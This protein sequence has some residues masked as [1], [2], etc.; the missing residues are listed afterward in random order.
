[1][2]NFDIHCIETIIILYVV[3]VFVIEKKLSRWPSGGPNRT[4]NTEIS[5]FSVRS[6]SVRSGNTEPKQILEED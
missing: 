1:M 2:K 4:K 6:G 3:N 5:V